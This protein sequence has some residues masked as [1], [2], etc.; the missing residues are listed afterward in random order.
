MVGGLCTSFVWMIF[1]HYQESAALGVCRLLFGTVNLAAGFPPTSWV[2][3]LQ[4]V[5]PLVVAL[6]IS[7]ALCMGV[8]RITQ[9]MPTAHL[10]RCFK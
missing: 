7:F 8:S 10:K 3:K 1:F 5:D 2:W 9:K 4:Y 6:P